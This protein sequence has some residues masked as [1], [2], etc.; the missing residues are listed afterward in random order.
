MSDQLER[1]DEDEE[2][3]KE[4]MDGRSPKHYP[5]FAQKN[6]NFTKPPK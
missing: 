3:L 6:T 5:H 2:K 1:S 4:W